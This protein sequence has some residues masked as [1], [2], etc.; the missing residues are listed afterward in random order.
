MEAASA[1]RGLP[2][3]LRARGFERECARLR[4]MGEAYARKRFG[5]Q[6]SDADAEDAVSEVL[7]RLHR[8]FEA[9]NPPKN[10]QAAFFT[11]VRNAAI[12]I[13][14]ARSA[15]PTVALEVAEEAAVV[16]PSPVER[17]ESSE[18][19]V[20]LQEALGRM[21]GNYREAVVLRFGL[22]LT[23][24]EIAERL[25]ISLPAAK[26][27]VLRASRQ[28]RSRL[29]AIDEHEFCEEMREAARRSVFDREATGLA[30]EG[31]AKVLHAHFMHCGP[32]R[33]F[34]ANL[35]EGLHELGGGAMLALLAGEAA[36]V[37]V[38]ALSRLR[39]V[40]GRVGEGLGVVHERT[41][42]GAFKAT[43]A[44]SSGD[45]AS[46]GVLAGSTQKIAA[47]CSVGA[48]SAA[49]CLASG[50]I[51]PGIGV[52]ISHHEH[53]SPPAKIQKVAS[54]EPNP[55]VTYEVPVE[56][57]ETPPAAEGGG[58]GEGGSGTGEAGGASEG[59]SHPAQTSTEIAEGEFGF[60]EQAEASSAPEVASAPVSE[61]PPP[62][63]LAQSS[64]SSSG[65][66]DFGGFEK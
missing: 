17:A 23:V 52:G 10:L 5:G 42:M 22:G 24:P 15:R 6:L 56:P 38:G 37:R 36:G 48:A 41:R 33:S 28:V 40:V 64:S 66:S 26:K 12:D 65:G 2:A 19:A 1:I 39:G 32:C 50:V 13:L 3:E 31:E 29:E 21:R 27:L 47:I 57:V 61:A 18:D 7:L 45:G 54:V 9:G 58:A 30:E 43:G 49:T 60:E 16:G 11:A 44:L 62:A 63:Q 59:A 34:L 35:H 20:R 46:A 14:R 25:G 55:V 8:Q 4:P 53:S 51:G